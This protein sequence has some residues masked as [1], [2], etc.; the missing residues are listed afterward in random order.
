MSPRLMTLAVT[1]AMLPAVSA[2][3]SPAQS[4]QSAQRH[5]SSTVEATAARQPLPAPASAKVVTADPKVGAI[6][7]NGGTVHVCSGAVLRS[8][9][10]DLILTAAHCLSDGVDATFVPG[11]DDDVGPV[12]SWQ[13]QATYLDPRWAAT[14]DPLADY[15]IARV[16][17]DAA[18][19]IESQVGGGYALGPTPAAGTDVTV[20]GY[21]FGNDA[22]PIQCRGRTEVTS[23]GYPA[24][25][26]AGLVDG[27]SGAPWVTG[28]TVTGLV[29][30]LNGGGCDDSVSYSPPFDDGVTQLLARA[31]AGGPGDAA[32]A[33]AGGGCPPAAPVP[34]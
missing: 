26:C 2:C 16:G 19:T 29:G 20:T 32:P 15:A 34:G 24:L 33:P 31:E 18:G 17:R 28:A 5:P 8:G 23:G 12:D 6:F 22:T 13:I 1:L 7:V 30:G 3:D 11:F 25:H 10:E 27:T 9:G 21:G 14:Q 4:A